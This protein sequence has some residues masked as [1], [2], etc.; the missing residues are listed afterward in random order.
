[1]KKTLYLAE[2][3]PLKITRD[4][5]SLW[6]EA[7]GQAGKRVPLRMIERVVVVG[8]VSLDS[9]IITLLASY[10]IPVFFFNKSGKEIALTLS[11]GQGR[12]RYS[13]RQ[14]IFLASKENLDRYINIMRSWRRRLQLHLLKKLLKDPD[15]LRWYRLHGIKEQ[16]YAELLKPFIERHGPRYRVVKEIV[17]CLFLELLITK[18]RS[19]GLEPDIGIIHYRQRMGLALDLCYIM[20]PEQHLL[21]IQTLRTRQIHQ[22]IDPKGVTHEGMKNIIQRFENKLQYLLPVINGIIENIIEAIEELETKGCIRLKFRG[23]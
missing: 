4:G 13:H 18:L 9:S 6:I 8:K 12:L 2:G 17:H 1:M 19:A 5:P 3:R 20:E 23:R 14:R 22:L 11:P 21:T 10:D 7:S 16:E 15:K